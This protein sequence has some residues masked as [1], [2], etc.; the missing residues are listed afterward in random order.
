MVH[1]REDEA[2]DQIF[3]TIGLYPKISGVDLAAPP[4]HPNCRSVSEDTYRTVQ[5]TKLGQ[6]PCS[7]TYKLRDGRFLGKT[8]KVRSQANRKTFMVKVADRFDDRNM[9]TNAFIKYV[10]LEDA[11]I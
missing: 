2:V 9:D 11:V 5:V 3:P 6:R 10:F 7:L 8:F 1:Q 4:Q